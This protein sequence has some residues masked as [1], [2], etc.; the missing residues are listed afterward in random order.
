LFSSVPEAF[1]RSWILIDWFCSNLGLPLIEEKA[2]GELRLN[3]AARDIVGSGT[4]ANV[5]ASLSPLLGESVDLATF[6]AQLERAR[7]GEPSEATPADG[8]R[9]LIAP[10]SPGHA[11]VVL[12]PSRTLEGVELQR[13][14]LATDRSAR[15]SHEL[16]NAL[17]AI[18]GWARL[19]KEG[20]HMDE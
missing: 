4:F 8:L 3:G 19:A 7:H 18:A 9:A 14:A 12:A 10:R 1:R 17:G 5:Y 2:N 11:C 6:E 13:R 15:V 20:A 16:A